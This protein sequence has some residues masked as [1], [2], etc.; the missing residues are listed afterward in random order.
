LSEAE[1]QVSS[2]P[3]VEAVPVEAAIKACCACHEPLPAR[4]RFCLVCGVAQSTAPRV[5]EDGQAAAEPM[6]EPMIEPIAELAAEPIAEPT[7]AS[8]HELA[9][10]AAP[11]A[12]PPPAPPATPAEPAPLRTTSLAPDV[13]ERLEKA[14]DD[15]ADIARSIEGLSRTLTVRSAEPGK[16]KRAARLH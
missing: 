14:R 16:P 7:P 10:E 12:A 6:I 13:V 4:A 15:I 11:E 2:V 5:G 9:P 3:P 1:D 8:A